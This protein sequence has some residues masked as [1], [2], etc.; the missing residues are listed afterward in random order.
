MER[1]KPNSITLAGS[2]LVRSQ[3][4]LR[5]LVQTSLE[6]DS[7]M[8]FGFYKAPRSRRIVCLVYRIAPKAEQN[9]E[10][11]TNNKN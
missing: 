4:P 6:P 8:E 9:N 5:Y 1:L 3:I 10:K 7:V 11:Y 2:E